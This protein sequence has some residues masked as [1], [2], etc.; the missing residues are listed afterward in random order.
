MK[1]VATLVFGQS[2][3]E[4]D[5]IP[6]SPV[7]LIEQVSEEEDSKGLQ[8]SSDFKKLMKLFA[9]VFPENF[10][11]TAPRS[12]PSEFTLGKAPK[13]SAFMKMVLSRSS[14]RALKMMN[15]WM[16]SKKEQGKTAFAFPPAKLASRSSLW[17]QTGESFGLGIPAS[18]RG[19]FSNLVD[20]SRR[21]AMGRTKFC[22]ST[23]EL[24]HL[25][26]GIFRAFE[27]F[28]FLDWTLGALGRKMGLFSTT[29]KEE[30]VHLMSCMDKGIRDGASELA[31]LFSA[32]ILKKRTH[33]CSFLANGVTSSQKA[34]LIYA[35]FS[36]H[37]F[38]QDLV[39]EIS[40][41]LAQ[42]TTQDLISK[43]AKKV[44]PTT[45]M[46]KKSKAEASV[47]QGSQP[48]RGRPSGR[49]SS[50]A[51]RRYAARSASRQGRNR[52]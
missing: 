36:S 46:T 5:D 41:S 22:W 40:T 35:P 44:L 39:K 9:E 12:P 19:D 8:L 4:I 34:E 23:S 3:E 42:K 43:T 18:S 30:L 31:A 13:E 50:R 16:L 47:L 21:V 29:D 48:F 33:L 24:D 7:D 52:T 15:E 32:G 45:F 37:L 38:P 6:Q 51:G 2:E 28:N 49:G 14:K 10:I 1:D 26:K 20:S 27:V 25:L 17:Y 11:P